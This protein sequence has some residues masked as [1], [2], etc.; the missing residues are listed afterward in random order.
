MLV[1]AVLDLVSMKN[2]Y[3]PLEYITFYH[4]AT[5]D[6]VVKSLYLGGEESYLCINR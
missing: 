2:D 1:V 6:K 4:S 3:S 5:F